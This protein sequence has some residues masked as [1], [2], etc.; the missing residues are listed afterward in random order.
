MKKIISFLFLFL[1]FS[2]NSKVKTKTYSIIVQA[3]S[4]DKT[5]LRGYEIKFDDSTYVTDNNGRMKVYFKIAG[6]DLSIKKRKMLNLINPKYL[7][8]EYVSY[9][10][11]LK[12]NWR[13]I[14]KGKNL[15]KVHKIYFP[16]LYRK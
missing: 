9:R 3:F 14:L 11:F 7:V 13:K 15:N 4:V 2:A 6:Y 5:I 10:Y 12:N 16:I 8:F 1:F